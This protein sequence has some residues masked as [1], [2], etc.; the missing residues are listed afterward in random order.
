MKIAQKKKKI[1][2]GTN[3]SKGN[4]RIDNTRNQINNNKKKNRLVDIEEMK[5][6]LGIP[7]RPTPTALLPRWLTRQCR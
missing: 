7:G 5:T 1:V 3:E 2:R 4:A 6:G